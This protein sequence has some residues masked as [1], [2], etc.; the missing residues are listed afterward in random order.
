[1]SVR[2][3]G[4]FFFFFYERIVYES[5]NAITKSLLLLG[6]GF[7]ASSS[8]CIST[9]TSARLSVGRNR[10]SLSVLGQL[11]EHFAA[12]ATSVS[13]WMVSHVGACWAFLALDLEFGNLACVVNIEVLQNGLGVLSV[14]VLY[15]LG[16]GV[17]LLLP[18]LLTTFQ[19]HCQVECA[20]SVTSSSWVL[21]FLFRLPSPLLLVLKLLVCSAWGWA[22]SF[23]PW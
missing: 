23:R 12:S 8:G 2:T 21:P 11:V 16:L 19:T 4:C 20:L 10:K 17:D 15:L 18:L 5:K 9:S 6:R 22:F 14:L 7:L 13:V 3:C 1:L